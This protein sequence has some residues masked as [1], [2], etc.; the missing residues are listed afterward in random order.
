MDAPNFGIHVPPLTWATQ[1][2][3]S[4]DGVLSVFASDNYAVRNQTGDFIFVRDVARANLLVLEEPRADFGVFNVAAGRAITI[5]ELA[6]SLYE[7][8]GKE[9]R[10][11]YAGRFRSGEVRHMTADVTKLAQLGFRA[12]CSLRDGLAQYVDWLEQ[13]GPV[14]EC[15]TDAERELKDAGVVRSTN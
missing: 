8:L 6:A 4:S 5:R 10:I 13:Q 3:F 12:E 2:K 9:A 7:C 11:E 14:P 15:F 1:Y